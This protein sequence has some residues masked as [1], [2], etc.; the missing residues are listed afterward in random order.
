MLI[1]RTGRITVKKID[2]D[3][4]IP[5]ETEGGTPLTD[6]EIELIKDLKRV[7]TKWNKHGQRLWL[8]SAAGTLHVMMKNGS[9]NEHPDFGGDNPLPEGVNPANVITTI[10]ITNDGGDW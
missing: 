3:Y 2:M 8:Y 9:G 4:W 6:K 5:D 1:W 10:D 7:S